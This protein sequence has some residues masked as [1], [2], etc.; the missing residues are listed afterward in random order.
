MK[1][2]KPQVILPCYGDRVFG[3]TGDDEMAM[4][5]PVGL[6]EEVIK[7]LAGTHIGG[8]RYPVPAY[9]GY[10]PEYPEHYDLLPKA[11]E[12]EIK[13]EKDKS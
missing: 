9:L 3:Q 13:E 11:W 5:I 10:T 7:G 4:S 8:I 12:E 6:E 2:G 1:T